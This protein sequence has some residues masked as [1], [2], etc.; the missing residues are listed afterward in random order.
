MTLIVQNGKFKLTMQNSCIS[1][2][3]SDETRTM[4]AKSKPAEIYMGSDTENVID[5][6]FNTLFFNVHK[7]H[8]MI[9]EANLFLIVLYYYIMIFKE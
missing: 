1:T 5:T 3:S 6:L 9:E 7:K 4:Y 8:K 2:K